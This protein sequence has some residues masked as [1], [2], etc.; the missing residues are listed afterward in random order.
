MS[1]TVK[2]MK[3][4]KHFSQQP[5][6]RAYNRKTGLYLHLSGAGE[7]QGEAYAWIGFRYQYEN[8][9]RKANIRGEDWPYHPVDIDKTTGKIA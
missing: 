8:L 1:M 3:Q 6:L 7:V 5:Y 4:D 9:L 2:L